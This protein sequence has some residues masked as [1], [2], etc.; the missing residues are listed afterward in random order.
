MKFQSVGNTLFLKDLAESNS[1]DEMFNHIQFEIHPPTKCSKPKTYAPKFT[2]GI[3]VNR[4]GFCEACDKWFKLKTSSYWYH[5]NYKH[6]IN[7]RGI[8]CPDPVFRNINKRIEGFCKD[9]DKW[10]FLGNT[11]KN[12]RFSWLRHWQKMHS[13]N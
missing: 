11:S 12:T 3:G 10:L 7:T 1:F 13:R 8:S 5:M 6:G 2:R 9:C 4:E